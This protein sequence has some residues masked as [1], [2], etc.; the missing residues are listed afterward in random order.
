MDSKEILKKA[1]ELDEAYEK[2]KVDDTDYELIVLRLFIEARFSRLTLRPF[3]T[4]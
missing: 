2:V 4:N 3:P 1:Q